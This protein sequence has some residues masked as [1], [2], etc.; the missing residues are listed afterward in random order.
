MKKRVLLFARSFLADFYSNIQS[1]IIDPIFVT[2][3][4]DEKRFLEGKNWRVYGCFEEEYTSLPVATYSSHYLRTSFA[5]DRFLC[6]FDMEKRKEILGKEIS[7]WS[8]ILDETTP[9]F[10]VN[11]TVAVEI[12]EVMALEAEKRNIPFYTTLGGFLADSFYW[13]PDPFS[14]RLNDLSSIEYTD[15]HLKIADDYLNDVREKNIQPFYVSSIKKKK[16]TLKTVLYSVYLHFKALKRQRSKEKN[17]VFCYEDYSIFTAVDI[18]R[19]WDALLGNYDKLDILDNKNFV[20]FPMHIEPEAT[21]NY[22][23]DEQFEQLSFIQLLACSIKQNQYLVVKEHPQQQG[24]LMGKEYLKLKKRYSN[25][26]YLPSYVKSYDII[27]HCDAIITFTS[28]A[29]WE[30]LVMGK[31]AFV[32]GKIFYDQCLGAIRIESLKQLKNGLS[33]DC[34]EKPDRESTRLFAARMISIYKKG[35]PSPYFK[36]TTIKD[37]VKE[38]EKL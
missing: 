31:P 29:A 37:F 21:L 7:F 35:R 33:K 1:D 2:L 36:G 15:E 34:Y 26:I 22:F 6:R 23:V 9:D 25:I 32:L 28:S 11:E 24:A 4:A 30:G 5:S 27:K 10:L 38:M 14:G 16:I 12:A 13:K 17:S 3:T 18:R 19:N 20:F 8:R